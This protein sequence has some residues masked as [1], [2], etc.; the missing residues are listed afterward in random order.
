MS[1][2]KRKVVAGY[3][4]SSDDEESALRKIPLGRSGSKRTNLSSAALPRLPPIILPLPH[5]CLRD[6]WK[7]PINIVNLRPAFNTCYVNLTQPSAELDKAQPSKAA[8]SSTRPPST[9]NQIDCLKDTSRARSTIAS[10]RQYNDLKALV[11]ESREAGEKKYQ[12]LGNKVDLILLTLN[13][14]EAMQSPNQ[15]VMPSSSTTQARD[16]SDNYQ[17]Y[18]GN[19]SPTT[20]LARIVSRVVATQKDRIGKK[21]GG[22][23]ENSLKDHTRRSWYATI[24]AESSSEIRVYFEHKNGEPDTLPVFFANPLTGYRRPHPHWKKSLAS[25]MEWIATYIERFR[26]MIPNNNSE[27]SSLLRGL[28]D[29][30]I[31]IMLHDGPFKTAVTVW[32]NRKYTNE[33][34]IRLQSNERRKHRATC[35]AKVRRL[36]TSDI[37]SLRGHDWEYLT[38]PGYMSPEE[39]DLEGEVITMRPTHRAAWVNNLFGAIRSAE[40]K[41]G[42]QTPGLV[43]VDAP[44]LIPKLEQRNSV[45]NTILRIP[46]CGLGRAW[47]EENDKELQESANL[48]NFS[49]TVK[50][51]IDNFLS[52]HPVD[53]KPDI[54]SQLFID[55]EAIPSDTGVTQHNINQ[56]NKENLPDFPI[57][58]ELLSDD[59]QSQTIDA[60]LADITTLADPTVPTVER[61]IAS[62]VSTHTDLLSVHNF[63]MPPPPPLTEPEQTPGVNKPVPKKRG[64]PSKKDSDAKSS[65]RTTRSIARVSTQDELEDQETETQDEDVPP[66]KRRG[67]PPG[68]K[69]K[70][71]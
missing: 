1:I 20:E 38:H 25:Q 55:N 19:P 35:K 45:S 61:A 12:E 60:E 58:P 27:L 6:S 7:L 8:K 42:A 26:A 59:A 30:Q 53:V 23:K 9:Q 52:E 63:E 39:S 40:I 11:D 2:P 51:F 18:P 48:V 41:R 50:P 10:E 29:E 62:S 49:L 15:G 32:R 13:R 56:D 31:V 36:Y 3:A 28:S 57:D 44:L 16:P 5:L 22:N 65:S 70:K 43:V 34:I 71:N 67:R 66:L 68:S 47:R 17:T 24:D 69:N 21:K 33:D 4:D 64:R 37:P 14:L 54:D 46:V